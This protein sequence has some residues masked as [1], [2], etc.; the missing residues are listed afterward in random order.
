MLIRKVKCRRRPRTICDVDGPLVR[1]G[2]PP[3]VTSAARM[4]GRVSG[5]LIDFQDFSVL[6]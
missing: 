2:L 4:D 5:L 1:P 3:V 6:F